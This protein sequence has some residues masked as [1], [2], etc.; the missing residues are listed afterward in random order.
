MK[1][2]MSLLLTAAMLLGLWAVS[3]A[4]EAAFTAEDILIEADGHT[5]PATLTLP[6]LKEG[7]RAP[8]V[9]PA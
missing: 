6:A 8:V 7:E 1:R 5:I 2:L 9:R 4:E 3:G